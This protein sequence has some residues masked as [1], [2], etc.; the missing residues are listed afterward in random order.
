MKENHQDEI[1]CAHKWEGW[2]PV[3]ERENPAKTKKLKFC[4]HPWKNSINVTVKKSIQAHYKYA[5]FRQIMALTNWAKQVAKA[6]LATSYITSK[7][8]FTRLASRKINALYSAND[9]IDTRQLHVCRHQAHHGE[10]TER[11]QPQAA[12]IYLADSMMHDGRITS[13]RCRMDCYHHSMFL[14]QYIQY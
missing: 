11:W 5:D 4:M 10:C 14:Q 9:R 3:K 1:N 12:S 2:C 8:T 6:R 13:S 7:R